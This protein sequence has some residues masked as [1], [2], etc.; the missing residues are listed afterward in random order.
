MVKKTIKY[1]HEGFYVA[2]VEIDL[3]VS[4][5][6]W[7]PTMSLKDA[8]KLDKIREYLR[9]GNLVTA[10]KYATIYEMHKIAV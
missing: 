8:L 4:N 7:S 10:V 1:I 9:V 6:G 2:E 3:V 5:S